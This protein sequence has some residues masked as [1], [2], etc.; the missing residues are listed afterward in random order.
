MTFEEWL[1]YGTD[2]RLQAAGGLVVLVGLALVLIRFFG[3][4]TALKI[5]TAVGAVF[6]ALAYGRRERQAGWEDA[7]AKGERDAQGALDQAGRARAD[8]DR[9]NAE[10]GRLRD[11][12]GYRRD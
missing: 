2:W 4:A 12:D 9:R 10:P 5:M 6:A 11:N 3:W 8:A 1:I 7:H